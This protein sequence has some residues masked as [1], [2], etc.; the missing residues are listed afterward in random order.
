MCV[1]SLL[2]FRTAG[3]SDPPAQFP[4]ACR[5]SYLRPTSYLLPPTYLPTYLLTLLQPQHQKVCGDTT[6]SSVAA[7]MTPFRPVGPPASLAAPQPVPKSWTSN[8]IC[9]FHDVPCLP[10]F[11]AAAR[12]FSLA[13]QATDGVRR[14]CSTPGLRFSFRA[15][16]ARPA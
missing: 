5:P 9:A 2:E 11:L 6:A 12:R 1:L 14:L 13:A 8:P 3:F 4:P 10:V 15:G 7:T 16:R